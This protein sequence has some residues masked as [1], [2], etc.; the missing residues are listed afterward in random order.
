MLQ[1]QVTPGT[2]EL[3]DQL[4][5]INDLP[6][7]FLIKNII[8]L[9]DHLPYKMLAPWSP[10]GVALESLPHPCHLTITRCGQLLAHRRAWP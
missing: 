9:A 6:I 7:G 1:L 4:E 3:A 2:R 8:S 10:L 5:I